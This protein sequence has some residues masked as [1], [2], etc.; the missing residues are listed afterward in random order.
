[1]QL[2]R[3]P[4]A[5]VPKQLKYSESN[6]VL[7]K[8]EFI[9][10]QLFLSLIGAHLN[11]L[12]LNWLNKMKVEDLFKTSTSIQKLVQMRSEFTLIRSGQYL[13]KEYMGFKR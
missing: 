9:L 10:M 5:I 11:I 7:L 8:G 12:I 6:N 2:S 13:L 1:M 4:N 3:N